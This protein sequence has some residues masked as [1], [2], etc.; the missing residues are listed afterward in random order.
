MKMIE[1]LKHT[2][3]DAIYD[4]YY[5]ISEDPK[6][7]EKT[8]GPKMIEEIIKIYGNPNTIIEIC[9]EKELKYIEKIINKDKSI[10][11]DK[12]V[13]EHK[14][15]IRKMIV[16]D[17][18]DDPNIYEETKECVKD[19]LER[20]NWKTV[21]E[22]DKINEVILGYLKVNGNSTMPAIMAMTSFILN[23]PQD[24]IEEWIDNN[25]LINYYTYFT[26]EYFESI[27]M[28]LD[29]INY[30]EY[31]DIMDEVNFQRSKQAISVAP[32]FEPKEYKEIFYTGFST[33]KATVR[34]LVEKINENG[35]FEIFFK[36]VILICA[37][38]NVD[39][40]K[41]KEAISN[42]DL[43]D[44]NYSKEIIKLLDSA[45]D[46]MPSGVL[47]GM[48][49]KQYKEQKAKK[50]ITEYKQKNEYVKQKN[51]HLS[52]AD[53]ELFYKLYFGVLEF[54]NRKYHVVPGLKIYQPKKLDPSVLVDVIDKFWS[55]KDSIIRE[56]TF[57]N[58]F[59]F[60][61]E[62][63][64][65]VKDFKKGIRDLFIVMKYEENY[66]VFIS[67]DSAYMVK[68]IT[69]NIDEI[70]PNED[71][72]APANTTLLPFKNQIVFD[73]VLTSYPV[74]VSA[75]MRENMIKEANNSKKIYKL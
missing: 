13:W 43:I 18:F 61:D 41:L 59:N 51:A 68:G 24:K 38:L 37:L 7:Y 39:R 35:L 11:N 52:K 33:K 21:K 23:M 64:K 12:Y 50:I 34:K 44:K 28:V 40:K 74:K 17:N 1:R 32:P 71:L 67:K 47:N 72:P 3:K 75:S 56:F 60:N 55:K 54:T 5:R 20:V 22:N 53:V 65:I 31:Y 36:D 2:S 69:C 66:T 10:H 26:E 45:M 27:D 25:K 58:P 70:I 6:E 42:K 30:T 16:D 63:M 46:D 48:T 62:E 49:P 29:I 57:A 15:L 4:A 14:E 9:T 8:T 19:A 73:S